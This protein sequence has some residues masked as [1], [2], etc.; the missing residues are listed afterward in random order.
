MS[1]IR[2]RN[3]SFL[4][5][6]DD[7][8]K[9]YV[10]IRELAKR[11]LYFLCKYVLGMTKM[12]T[13]TSIHY[14]EC[15]FLEGPQLRKLVVMFRKSFKTSIGLGNVVRWIINNPDEQI[16]VGSDM[17]DRAVKR[18]EQLKSWFENCAPLRYLFPEVCYKEPGSESD[19][20]TNSAFNVRRSSHVGGFRMPTVSSF[21]IFPLPTGAHFTKVLMDD[22]EHE[23]NINTDILVEQLCERVSAFIPVLDYGAEYVQ[24]G[25]PYHP[26]G[27]NTRWMNIWPTYRIPL[28]DKYGKSTFPSVCTP[29]WMEQEK[30]DVN[31]DYTWHTQYLLEHYPRTAKFFF[32]FRQTVL[33][34][35]TFE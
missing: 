10:A 33:Q 24:L 17:E 6:I 25:T 35:F 1:L 27:P 31:N 9:L 28:L 26:D 34:T 12:E 8:E 3:Y 16:G 14:G 22:V 11:D 30:A 2:K 4:D 5:A 32:P 7:K 13:K 23:A 18:V 19:K 20:W 21:G 29:E 15:D